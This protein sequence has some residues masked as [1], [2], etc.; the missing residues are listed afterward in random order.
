M[1]TKFGK[2][3]FCMRNSLECGTTFRL[4]HGVVTSPHYPLF[5]PNEDMECDYRIE[6][7]NDGALIITLKILDL[8]LDPNICMF[9]LLHSRNIFCIV[10]LM[11][12]ML[13]IS[14]PFF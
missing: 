2:T 7:E 1:K 8:E 11:Q 3:G 5:Y 12:H 4:N 6:P 9:T 14:P 10:L 13:C